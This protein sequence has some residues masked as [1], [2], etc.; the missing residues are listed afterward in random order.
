MVP[1][2]V[3]P[4][5]T[6]RFEVLAGRLGVEVDGERRYAGR[7]EVVVVEPGTPHRF[8]NAGDAEVRFLHGVANLPEN[9]ESLAQPAPHHRAS[10]EPHA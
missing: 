5:E 8:W 2:H 10:S 3:H 7:G 9:G 4:H 6:E 1:A